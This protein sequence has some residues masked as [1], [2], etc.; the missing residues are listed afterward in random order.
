[1][2]KLTR[3]G[4]AEPVW[5]DQILRCVLGQENIHFPCS[6][7]HEQDYRQPYPVNHSFA[8][9]DDNIYIYIYV[10][11]LPRVRRYRASSSQGNSSYG[12]YL[13]RFHHGPLFMR[14]YFPAPSIIGM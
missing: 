7:D 4:T 10:N 9:C 2:I 1:M 11:I 13:F 6:A 14:L 5:R 12:C 3:Y 8:I